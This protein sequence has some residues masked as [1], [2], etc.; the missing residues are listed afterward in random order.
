MDRA[1]GR[2]DVP[3]DTGEPVAYA[4][5]AILLMAAA[6]AAMLGPASRAAAIDPLRAIRDE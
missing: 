1:F 4:G 3:L 5:V 2:T 6:V